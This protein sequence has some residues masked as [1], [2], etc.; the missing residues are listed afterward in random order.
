MYLDNL[1][2]GDS[3]ITLQDIPKV[4]HRSKDEHTTI[5]KGTVGKVSYG[6][7]KGGLV[8]YYVIF[9]GGWNLSGVLPNWMF[10][11]QENLKEQI[12]NV[13]QK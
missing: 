3:V 1:N 11:K 12:K 10:K 8:N 7:E 9:E 6:I 2:K 13:L 5:L 4:Y